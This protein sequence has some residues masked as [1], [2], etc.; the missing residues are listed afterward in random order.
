MGLYD[1]EL[2]YDGKPIGSTIRYVVDPVVYPPDFSG[3]TAVESTIAEH[4]GVT[5]RRRAAEVERLLGEAVEL[6]DYD[7]LDELYVVDEGPHRYPA[8]A[9]MLPWEP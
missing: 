2:T 4:V 9:S 3:L 7:H 1:Y 5:L 6:Q 8:V